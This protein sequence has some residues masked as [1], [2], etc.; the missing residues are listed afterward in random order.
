MGNLNKVQSIVTLMLENR[1]FD[2]LFGYLYKNNT[3]PNGDKI[4]GLTGRETNPAKDG[5]IIK[6]HREKTRTDV[7]DP[8]PGEPYKNVNMQLFSARKPPSPPVATNKGFVLDYQ[9]QKGK[10]EEIMACYDPS[11]IPNFATICSRY[12]VCDAWHASVPSQTW[13][14]R[15]FAHAATSWGMVDNF[16]YDPFL[17][18]M[19]TIFQKMAAIAG[20]TWRIYYDENYT[21]FTRLQFA[22]LLKPGYSKNILGFEHFLHDANA[23]QL[24]RYAFVEPNFFHNPLTKKKQSD[25]HPPSDITPGDEFIARVFNAIV[26]GP[27]W[28][29]GE[30]LLI[31]TFD[32]HGG[33]YDHVPPPLTATRPDNRK[34]EFG[35]DFKRFGVRVPA[36]VVSP[37]VKKGSVFHA[38]EGAMPYDHT[39][40]IATIT[41]RFGMANL[42]KRDAKAPDLDA[43]LTEAART[44]TEP[45]SI[46]APKAFALA[47]IAE[48]KDL[49]AQPLNDLQRSIV[50]AMRHVLAQKI[51]TKGIAPKA[52]ARAAA[53]PVRTV[54]DA[55]VFFR[56]AKL[57]TGL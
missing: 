14:N 27:Q 52:A 56:E 54:G 7:P 41:R 35:F 46:A 4:D 13:T 24:P 50:D 6:V 16:P 34:G 42:T 37:F 22:P 31:I 20:M 47:G 2:N 36:V 8:D 49:A 39:S 17:W 23:G 44:D 21:S 33:C 40:I 30:V 10:P 25:M 48:E 19:P 18:R 43:I 5:T 11:L 57:A 28:A 3:S 38:A 53:Q 12:A 9:G 29:K 15:A 32:E 55:Q 1:S 26:T 45:L 51:Q